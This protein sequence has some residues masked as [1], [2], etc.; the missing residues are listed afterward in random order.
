MKDPA[1]AGLVDLGRRVLMS[2]AALS[3]SLAA[4]TPRSASTQRLDDLLGDSI[5]LAALDA[6]PH[7]LGAEDEFGIAPW[8]VKE[9]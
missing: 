5:V 4:T 8:I 6:L 9:G 1:S 3:S 2:A 7:A